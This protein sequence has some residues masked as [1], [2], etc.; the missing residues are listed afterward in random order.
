MTDIFFKI[1]ILFYFIA[2]LFYLLYLMMTKR[3]R[4]AQIATLATI[5]G[6]TCHSVSLIIKTVHF[7]HMS[8]IG[9]NNI[10]SFLAW[11]I[12]LVY[13]ILEWKHKIWVMGSFVLPLAFLSS[14][15]ASFLPAEIRSVISN[16]PVDIRPVISKA[17]KLFL[18]VHISLAI[19]GFASFAVACCMGIMYLLQEKQLKSHRPNFLFFRLPALD[20]LDRLSYRCISIGFP[21]LTVSILIG[22][23]GIAGMRSSIFS[24]RPIE[25]W[26][27]AI[28][29]FYALLLQARFTA[30]WRGRKASYLTILIFILA[31]LPV[32]L[33]M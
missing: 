20:T 14:L 19:I 3:Q 26:W 32:V 30:G 5:A 13:L 33:M 16:V 10:L 29:V 1:G 27:F 17:D 2:T 7:G 24:W 6:F 9:A 4:I 12:V 22:L 18:I 25:I 21:V 28:W 11:T 23:A 8:L 15:Y 31:L